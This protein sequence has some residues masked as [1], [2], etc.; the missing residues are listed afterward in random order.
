MNRS[1]VR[2]WIALL[3]LPLLAA[4]GTTP[5][6]Q[7]YLLTAPE[8]PLPQGMTPSI[9]VG[10][11]TVPEYLNRDSLVK[12]IDSN[13]L[14]ISSTER[15]AEPLEDGI[16]RVVALNLA[17]LLQTE[18][19]RLYPWHPKRAPDYG[20]KLRLVE[21]DSNAERVVL[22]AEWFVYRVADDSTVARRLSKQSRPLPATTQNGNEVAAAY[23]ELLYALSQEVAA[24]IAEAQGNPAAVSA[25]ST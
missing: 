20:V 22:V 4:C 19:V 5:S 25:P 14:A 9:G 18:N 7:H 8:A 13:S 6:S 16:L 12:R 23:S 15:W 10:P 1:L 24:S 11:I 3:L 2:H 17:G 21:M